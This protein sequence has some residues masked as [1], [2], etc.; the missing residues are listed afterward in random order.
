MIPRFVKRML[1]AT[2][3]RP[4]TAH[5]ILIGP[6]RGMTFKCSDN[7]GLAALYSGN[8]RANQEVYSQVVRL[9]DTVIDAG[10]NW[11]VHTLYLARLV[12]KSGQVHAFEPHPQVVEEL[13]WHV[14]RNHLDQVTVHP[15]GLLDRECTIPFVLGDSSKTSHIASGSEGAQEERLVNVRF[16]T[17]DSLVEELSITAVRLIKIDVEGAEGRT[18]QGATNTI[19]RFRPHLVVEL[20]SPEQDLEV[21]RTLTSWGYKL[22]RVEGPELLHLDLPWPAPNGVWGTLHAV[23]Q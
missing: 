21:A 13:S 1:T 9:G 19:R 20:H 10:A 22:S 18:L 7:T 8:E 2:L 14:R 17:L 23:P 11:G 16:R 15:Y 5:T 3:Y 12:G 4:G 6:M